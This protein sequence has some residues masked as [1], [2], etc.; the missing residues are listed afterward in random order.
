MTVCLILIYIFQM[1]LIV[2]FVIFIILCII[3][4]K[5]SDSL[6][7]LFLRFNYS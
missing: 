1:K 7:L 6:T 4:S 2:A 5:Y 3:L